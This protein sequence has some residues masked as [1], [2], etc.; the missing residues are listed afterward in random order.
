MIQY[1]LQRN[2][3]FSSN[4]I[5]NTT[6]FKYSKYFQTLPNHGGA[7]NL[8]KPANVA[9]HISFEM[10]HPPYP[11]NPQFSTKFVFPILII[12]RY[13]FPP[14]EAARRSATNVNLSNLVKSFLLP[15]KCT[16]LS[17]SRRKWPEN[18]YSMAETTAGRLFPT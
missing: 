14:P 11:H 16:Q 7:K 8:K 4:K 15:E 5:F 17:I 2:P 6:H 9:Q 3:P 10:T 18:G 1:S 12:R 13:K